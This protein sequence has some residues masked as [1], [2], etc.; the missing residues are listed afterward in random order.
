MGKMKK[1]G[2]KPAQKAEQPSFS[3]KASYRDGGCDDSVVLSVNIEKERITSLSAKP[4]KNSCEELKKASV[5]LVK[6]VIGKHIGDI[7]G[8]SPETLDD[9]QIPHHS[10]TLVVHALREAILVYESEKADKALRE[11]LSML[12]DYDKGYKQRDLKTDFEY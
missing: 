4:T 2:R 1:T 12:Q 5:L 10:A 8:I 9:S 11:A 7:Y 3:G 6:H